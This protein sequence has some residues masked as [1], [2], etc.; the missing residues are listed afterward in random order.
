MVTGRVAVTGASGFIGRHLVEHLAAGGAEIV[1]IRRPF[2]PRRLAEALRG[3]TAVVHLAGVV[4]AVRDEAYVA[5][6]V[7]ATGV[8]A[9][10]ARDA[11]VPLIH[12]S[13]LAAAGPAPPGAPRAEDDP[14]TP[15]NAYGR[16]KLAGERLVAAC[17]GL[18]W[19]I[20]RPGVVYG[21]RDRA[22]LPLFRFAARGVL[23]LVGREDAAFTFIHVADLVRT[24]DAALDHPLDGDIVFAGHRDPVSTRGLLESVAAAAGA[25]ARLIRV[26]MALTHA[27]AIAGDIAGALSGKPAL[28]NSRRYVELDS[29]GF[30]CRVDRLRERLGIVAGIG[31]ADGL[32]DTYAWYRKEGWL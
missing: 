24:I 31:L 28:I 29:V 30:V 5:A 15:I 2:E 9:R 13:S 26:P 17:D 27:A 18:R 19:T 32:A 20:L 12:I 16:S 14:A 8:V 3:V 21:P 7:D 4:A 6:N 25:R 11:A 23:P 10:A 1:A 22:L